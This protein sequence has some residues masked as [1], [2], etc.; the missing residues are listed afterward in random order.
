[1]AGWPDSTWSDARLHCKTLQADLAVF[2]DNNNPLTRS[3]FLV[4]HLNLT[5]HW[6]GMRYNT[7]LRNFT[8]LDGDTVS[9]VNATVGGP[10]A[11]CGAVSVSSGALIHPKRDDCNKKKGFIC[12]LAFFE[13]KGKISRF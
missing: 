12:E 2:N 5:E 7:T 6:I 3:P 8:W 11:T 10:D 4:S 1:M 9:F 13:G